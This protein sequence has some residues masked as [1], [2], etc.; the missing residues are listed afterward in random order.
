MKNRLVTIKSYLIL[1]PII[2]TFTFREREFEI[3]TTAN[4]I[5]I[6]VGDGECR[7]NEITDSQES[8]RSK[9][10][11]SSDTSIPEFSL[12]Y[13]ENEEPPPASK[14]CRFVKNKRCKR[15]EKKMKDASPPKLLG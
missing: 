2:K 9:S 11:A 10:S 4:P 14:T 7:P 1:R 3:E 8:A 13:C 5:R 6:L 12:Q 15:N